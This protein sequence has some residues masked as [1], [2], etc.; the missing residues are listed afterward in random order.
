MNK[1]VRYQVVVHYILNYAKDHAIL[2]LGRVPGFKRDDIQL[3]TSAVTKHE[4]WIA[5]REATAQCEGAAAVCYS[6]FG[7]LWRQLTPQVV[8]SKPMTVL[9]LSKEQFPHLASTQ[10]TCGG[11]DRGKY[12]PIC[13]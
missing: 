10:P 5:Y 1:A 11:E 9:D 3:L 4:V 8:V 13:N 6:L 2:L 12:T 7:Q